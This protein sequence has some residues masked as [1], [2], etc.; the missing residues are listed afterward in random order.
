MTRSEVW[1]KTCIGA[2]RTDG[3]YDACGP[4]AL[5][6]I[7]SY[8][9]LLLLFALAGRSV[10]GALRAAMR[11][12]GREP[13]AKLC[14]T[15]RT[16]ARLAMLAAMLLFTAHK[17]ALYDF[18]FHVQREIDWR[19]PCTTGWNRM[20]L[21]FASH[22]MDVSIDAYL[23]PCAT[24]DLPMLQLTRLAACVALG[25][26]CAVWLAV[27]VMGPHTG[28][29]LCHTVMLLGTAGGAA[30]AA[31]LATKLHLIDDFCGSGFTMKQLRFAFSTGYVALWLTLVACAAYMTAAARL[32]SRRATR[33]AA[34]QTGDSDASELCVGC[35]CCCAADGDRG[36]KPV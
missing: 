10:R 7:G 29:T 27:H 33:A 23:A 21:W 36:D 32:E 22:G 6:D 26:A 3:C 28:L 34:T 5:F 1:Q 18:S 14:G 2:H 19:P 4:Q 15:R 30:A 35:C 8:W 24:R 11:A 31:L 9:V 16:L 12:A 13:P 17:C 20:G 25:S